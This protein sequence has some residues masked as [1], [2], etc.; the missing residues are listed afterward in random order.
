MKI[1]KIVPLLLIFFSA[2]LFT[3][4]MGLAEEKD[5]LKLAPNIYS[6]LFENERVRVADIHFKPGDKIAMHSHP[7]HIL[8]I[9]S[10]GKIKLT[11][12]DGNFKEVEAEPGRV[13]WSN[14]ESHA[15]ENVGTTEFHAVIVELKEEK[16]QG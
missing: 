14:A 10:E 12:P 13:M 11:Y 15:S 2:F 4:K 6:L 3:A 7:D 9:L 1:K 5:P 8:Y 16:P